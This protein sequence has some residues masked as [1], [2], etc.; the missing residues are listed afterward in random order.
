MRIFRFWII[1]KAKMASICRMNLKR[2][3][4]FNAAIQMLKE[5]LVLR[6]CR[7]LCGVKQCS[8]ILL[9]WDRRRVEG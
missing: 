3:N 8:P 1:V 9:S 2:I 5:K 4:Q 6:L 7:L